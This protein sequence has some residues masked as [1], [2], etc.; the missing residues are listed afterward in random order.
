MVAVTGCDNST[1]SEQQASSLN[2]TA[3]TN[4]FTL[5]ITKP[6]ELEKLQEAAA[7]GDP[8][9]QLKLGID[10]LE[11]N[12]GR[13]DDK[14]KAE[15][16]LTKASNQGQLSAQARLSIMRLSTNKIS[17]CLGLIDKEEYRA[18]LDECVKQLQFVVVQP[19]I[20]TSQE[21]RIDREHLIL[22]HFELGL[23]LP[24]A[25]AIGHLKQADALGHQ[26][27]KFQIGFLLF[28]DGTE[29]SKLECL[30]YFE[31]AENDSRIKASAVLGY[32]HLNGLAGKENLEKAEAAF[33]EVLDL[34]AVEASGNQ[35]VQFY[36]L[37]GFFS[38]ALRGEICSNGKGIDDEA[39]TLRWLEVSANFGHQTA[40]FEMGKKYAEGNGVAPDPGAADKWFKMALNE[41]HEEPL[42][43]SSKRP[44]SGLRARK[45]GATSRE[46]WHRDSKSN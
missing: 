2:K 15:E 18:I 7:N 46:C 6:T 19:E 43:I 31:Q 38:Y 17:S 24:T 41:E 20:D 44:C 26:D 45:R 14:A 11:G 36:L 42:S 27:A 32:I 16:W 21:L 10:F 25:E 37:A 40:Q 22:S 3:S 35:A 4:T 34:V 28:K 5:P 13:Y 29:E 12:Y 1:Q 9:A 23:W 8:V 30:K 33:Q 39:E